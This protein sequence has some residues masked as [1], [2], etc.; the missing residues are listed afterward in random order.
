MITLN[1][2]TNQELLG[3]SDIH[4]HP[5]HFFELLDRYKP[6]NDLIYVIIG[7]I[8][9]KG[10]GEEAFLKIALKIKEL[11]NLGHA[12]FVKGNHELK[13]IK[14]NRK[15]IDN[16]S[17]YYW[18]DLQPIAISFLYPNQ[19][20]YTFVH[21]GI[22]PKMTWDTISKDINVCYTRVLDKYGNHVHMIRNARTETWEPAIKDVTEWHD[23]YDGRFGYVVS[24]HNCSAKNPT[25]YNYSCNIDSGVFNTGILSA[26]TFNQAGK[27][28]IIQIKGE[29]YGKKVST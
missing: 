4:E 26:V 28:E 10:H 1:L 2:K 21:A 3:V 23:V 14:K 15:T 24:G 22:T 19:A 29:P 27:K 20:R 13:A 11:V 25:F 17:I 6:S 7:D 12:F 18:I 9:D 8:K 5:D 16:N